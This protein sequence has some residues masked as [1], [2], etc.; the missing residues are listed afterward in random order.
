MT[1]D[2]YIQAKEAIELLGVTR[3]WFYEL[4]RRYGYR[5]NVVY[6]K[7]VYLRKD[8]ER[9]PCSAQRRSA[10]QKERWK[11]QKEKEADP[12]AEA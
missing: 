3:T 2:K 12:R 8:I 7:T 11:R 9:T 10:A 6:G 4:K 1:Q 5:T